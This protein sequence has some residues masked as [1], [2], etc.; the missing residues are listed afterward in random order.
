LS[1]IPLGALV[2]TLASTA[3][4]S[5]EVRDCLAVIRRRRKG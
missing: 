3:L 4:R 5:N 1:G 2:Y